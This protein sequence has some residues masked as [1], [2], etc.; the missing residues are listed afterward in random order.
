M[1]VH[2]STNSGRGREE[3][4]VICR[5]GSPARS[6]DRAGDL[7]GVLADMTVSGLRPSL[8]AIAPESPVILLAHQLEAKLLLDHSGQKPPDRVRLP[9]GGFHHFIQ[10]RTFCPLEK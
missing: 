9:A 6:A 1:R 7:P 4:A 5:S 2:S 3:S 10:G 8:D